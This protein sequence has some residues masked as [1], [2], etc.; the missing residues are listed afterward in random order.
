[1]HHDEWANDEYNI[2]CVEKGKKEYRT[3]NSLSKFGESV[4]YSTSDCLFRYFYKESAIKLFDT[5]GKP[6]ELAAFQKKHTWTTKD[7]TKHQDTIWVSYPNSFDS[8]AFEKINDSMVWKVWSK[9]W[10]GGPNF[11]ESLTQYILLDTEVKKV[12]HPE[13][14]FYCRYYAVNCKK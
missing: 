14:Y 3:S 4:Y 12:L 1:M 11:P 2:N 5:H 9:Y 13:L 8:L 6:V 7:S 10:P